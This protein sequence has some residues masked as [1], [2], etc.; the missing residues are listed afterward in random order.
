[1]CA[2]TKHQRQREGRHICYVRL[3]NRI[4]LLGLFSVIALLSLFGTVIFEYVRG[5][6]SMLETEHQSPH[7]EPV[8]VYGYTVYFLLCPVGQLINHSQI[9]IVTKD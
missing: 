4:L 3:Q 2:R 7:P 1:M 5:G 8:H 6:S 9:L